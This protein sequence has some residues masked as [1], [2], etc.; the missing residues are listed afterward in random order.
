MTEMEIQ[1]MYSNNNLGITTMA[2]DGVVK[3]KNATVILLP[4]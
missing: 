1:S 4:R 2:A 3:T